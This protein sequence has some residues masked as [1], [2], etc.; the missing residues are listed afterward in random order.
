ASRPTNRSTR[1]IHRIGT[2]VTV[3]PHPTGAHPPK[4]TTTRLVG[5][6]QSPVSYERDHPAA[7][8]SQGYKLEIGGRNKLAQIALRSSLEL[9]LELGF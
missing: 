6:G 5:L 7:P 9:M 4:P 3:S 1:F 2:P 8:E